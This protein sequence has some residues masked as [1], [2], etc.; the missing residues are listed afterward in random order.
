VLCRLDLHNRLPR[1]S[2]GCHA[3][4][5]MTVMLVPQHLRP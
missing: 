4:G 2:S 3:L 5:T 1:R